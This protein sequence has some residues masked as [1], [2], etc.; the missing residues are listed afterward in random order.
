MSPSVA[1]F[2]VAVSPI[3]PMS[4]TRY[5]CNE[6]RIRCTDIVFKL[7]E[8]WFCQMTLRFKKQ[9]FIRAERQSGNALSDHELT[10]GLNELIFSHNFWS[11]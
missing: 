2:W 10:R 7:L 4:M 3:G 6:S 11:V 1:L 9:D 5:T 8:R